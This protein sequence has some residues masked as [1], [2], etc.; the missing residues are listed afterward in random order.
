MGLFDGTGHDGEAGSTAELARVTGWPVVLVVDARGQGASVAALLR[1]FASHQPSVPLAGVIFNRVSSER[2]GALL[3]AAAARHLPRL[4]C[5]GSLPADP[6]LVVPSRHLGL[7]PA[8]RKWR[9]RSRHRALCRPYRRLSRCRAAVELGPR[10]GSHARGE[11]R[12]GAASGSAHCGSPRRGVL[13]RLSRRARGLAEPG[14]RTRLLLAARGRAARRRSRCRLPAGR[15]PRALGGS[16]R[17]GGDLHR[18]ASAG[19]RQTGRRSMANAAATW[20]SATL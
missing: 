17:I 12:P 8:A 10:L 9:C 20:F 18:P 6:G 7:V 3:A 11:S 19:P 15:L 4:A 16:A 13:L 1:G 2:H 5:L 14:R